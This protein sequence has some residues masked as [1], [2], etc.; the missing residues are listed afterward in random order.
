MSLTR[1]MQ[2][3]QVLLTLIFNVALIKRGLLN[4]M[5][6]FVEAPIIF[7]FLPDIFVGELQSKFF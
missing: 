6:S 2:F 3:Q 5:P 1:K 4:L 7:C